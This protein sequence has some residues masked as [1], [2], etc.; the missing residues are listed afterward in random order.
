LSTI[1]LGEIAYT[2]ERRHGADACRNALERLAVFPIQ[3]QEAMREQVMAAAHLK[4]CYAISYADA[5]A[6][7]LAQELE[8]P[9]V[10]GDREFAQVESLVDV[11]WLK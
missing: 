9:V 6:A 4:A 2:V 1:S 5:F 3:I 10:T 11:L 7:A 8:A